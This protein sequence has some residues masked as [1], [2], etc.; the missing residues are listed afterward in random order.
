M[1]VSRSLTDSDVD[2]GSLFR[3]SVEQCESLIDMVRIKIGY[4][5]CVMSFE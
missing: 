5:C 2:L 1:Y 4:V 3:R